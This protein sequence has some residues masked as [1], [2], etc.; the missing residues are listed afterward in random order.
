MVPDH[1]ELASP[2]FQAESEDARHVI[3]PLLLTLMYVLTKVRWFG[4]Q[5]DSQEAGGHLGIE[6]HFQREEEPIYSGTKHE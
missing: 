3:I 4:C 6:L 5:G 2:V 1:P